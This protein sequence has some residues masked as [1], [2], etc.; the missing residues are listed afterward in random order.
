MRCPARLLA[1]GVF[2]LYCATLSGE[3]GSTYGQ[4]YLTAKSLLETGDLSIDA[5]GEEVS[6]DRIGPTF[7]N[8]RGER[9]ATTGL[10][11]AVV[12][13]PF[14]TL[15][16]LATG[17]SEEG[18]AGAV[19]HLLTGMYD[20]LLYA[21]AAALLFSLTLR[22][23]QSPGWAWGTVLLWVF[24]TMAWGMS[25]SSSYLSLLSCLLLAVV[26]FLTAPMP[27]R[28]LAAFFAAGL[29][30]ALIMFA[31]VQEAVLMPA[32]LLYAY[33]RSRG[34]PPRL[35]RRA[36]V[37]FA[38]PVLAGVLGLVWLNLHRFSPEYPFGYRSQPLGPLYVGLWGLLFS[39]GR[40]LFLFSPP[41][42][43]GV[44]GLVHASRQWRPER[45][46]VLFATLTLLLVYGSF[47]CW[48]G[49]WGDWGP[50]YLFPLTVL[51][52]LPAAMVDMT[53]LRAKASRWR[54]AVLLGLVGL[55]VQ[56]PGVLLRPGAYQWPLR[57]VAQRGG[58]LDPVD[59][60]FWPQFSPVFVGYRL[61]AAKA[62][63][64]LTGQ[65]AT[66]TLTIWDL[67]GPVREAVVSLDE[68]MLRNNDFVS[69]LLFS[70]RHGSLSQSHP[71][72]LR[73]AVLLRALQAL[74]FLAGLACLAAGGRMARRRPEAAA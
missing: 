28:P 13:V 19:K 2:L 15:A 41:L 42:V 73:L 69:H 27:V 49:D 40:S 6:T 60:Y 34:L 31:R 44:W 62:Q 29:C 54:A 50:R 70:M 67:D 23:S 63:T 10:L 68:E 32:C 16:R 59:T 36:M 64:V 25:K 26:W 47:R 55:L 33:Q 56:V 1:L 66:L 22:I 7:V 30:A 61:L 53:S 18:A 43:L 46:F 51:L 8:A 48:P 39:S 20:P 38:L 58:S 4:A 45:N 35:R 65:P 57:V 11:W 72:S 3:G 37:L 71:Y 17:P 9:H 5:T 12:V 21:F 14:Y 52:L 24:A 74:P